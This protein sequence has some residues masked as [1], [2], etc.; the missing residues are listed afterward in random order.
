MRETA[1]SEQSGIN[2]GRS[3][4]YSKYIP[5]PIFQILAT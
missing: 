3:E 4:W 2:G 5:I 1:S